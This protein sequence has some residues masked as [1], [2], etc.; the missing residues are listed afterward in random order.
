MRNHRVVWTACILFAFVTRGGAEAAQ[1]LQGGVLQ[2]GVPEGTPTGGVLDLSL[3]DAVERGLQRNLGLILSLEAVSEASGTRTVEKADLLPQLRA[4]VSF[5][6]QK[7]NLDAFG[8]T[9]FPGVPQVIGPFNVFDARAYAAQTLLDFEA[10]ASARASER[11]LEAREHD[12]KSTRDDVVLA[13]ASLYLR[14]LAAQSLIEATKAQL[15]TAEA[16][17]ELA[18]HRKESGLAP[19]IDVLRAQF[20]VQSER[21][22]VIVSENAAKKLKLALARAIGLPV[23]QEFRLTDEMPFAPPPIISLEDAIATAYENRA[24]L[25]ASESRVSAAEQDEQAARGEG[26]P[27]LGVAGDFGA[28]GQTIAGS[29][30]T[31]S[32]SA[33]VNV[34]L[35]EGGRVRGKVAEAQAKLRQQ[36]AIRDDLKA[37]VDYEVR[38]TYGDVEAARERVEVSDAGLELAREQLEQAKDRFQAGVAGNIDVVQAQESVARATESRIQSLYAYNAAKAELARALGTAESAF[39][40]FLRGSNP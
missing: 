2:G 20:Q 24:D 26:L 17:H 1:H 21:Q 9:G 8:F 3:S 28:I 12:L 10:R 5:I 33:G 31:Y 22:R 39:V 37:G 34:P 35:F 25:K 15:E 7:V 36:Q 13:C 38:A 27:S 4:R 18:Q 6:N 23:G 11:T 30:A 29:R 32:V 14:V 16:L 40:T 19:G